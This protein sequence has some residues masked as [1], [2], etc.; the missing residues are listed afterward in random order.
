MSFTSFLPSVA[1]PDLAGLQLPA[2]RETTK[3]IEEACMKQQHNQSYDQ[4]KGSADRDVTGSKQGMPGGEIGRGS[5]SSGSSNGRSS[6]NADYG[7]PEGNSRERKTA[8]NGS[9]SGES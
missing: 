5:M 8:R 6:G 3:R 9:D 7:G 4:K 2:L 1:Y